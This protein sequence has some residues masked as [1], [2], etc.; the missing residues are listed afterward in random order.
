MQTSSRPHTVP[1]VTEE[2]LVREHLFLVS[3][4]VAGVASRIP[5]HVCRDDLVSAAMLALGQAARSYDPSTGVP[6]DRYATARMRGALVDELRSMDWAGRPTR[7]LGR[8]VADTEAQLAVGLGRQPTPEEVTAATG[9][10]ADAVH[11]L[12]HDLDRATVLNYDSVVLDGDAE[13]ILPATGRSAE[14]HLL[15]RERRGYLMDAVAVLPD[16]LRAVVVGYFLEERPMQDIADELGVT[17]SRVSQM[18]S[19]AL[20]LLRDG[21]NTHLDPDRV[22]TPSRPRGAAARRRAAYYTAVGS[23]SD[24]RSRL[25]PKPVVVPSAATG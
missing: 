14:D 6:F 25:D 24:Y 11:K 18:R 19:E 5:P 2:Q 17:E 10:D 8:Q 1:S 7:T 9:L 3:Q 15:E 23:R 4:L 16:R 21:L 12:R 22:T 20:A 13:E